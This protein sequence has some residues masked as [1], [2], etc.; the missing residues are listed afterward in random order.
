MIIDSVFKLESLTKPDIDNYYKLCSEIAK[1]HRNFYQVLTSKC[2]DTVIFNVNGPLI[3]NLQ[4][5]ALETFGYFLGICANNL[6]VP[7]LLESFLDR[8][9]DKI[10]ENYKLK[11]CP[12]Y[13]SLYL[14]AAEHFPQVLEGQQLITLDH[15]YFCMKKSCKEYRQICSKIF[16]LI[17]KKLQIKI[18]CEKVTPS[19][20]TYMH[21]ALEGNETLEIYLS[22]YPGLNN[23][24]YGKYFFENA[25]SRPYLRAKR[26]AEE[27]EYLCD[28]QDELNMN[29]LSMIIGNVAVPKE[30]QLA[31]EVIKCARSSFENFE[32]I[33]S[34]RRAIGIT[35]FICELYKINRKII[36]RQEFIEYSKQMKI[37][38]L[39]KKSKSNTICLLN[40]FTTFRVDRYLNEKV[41]PKMRSTVEELLRKF[42]LNESQLSDNLLA[43]IERENESAEIKTTK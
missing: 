30:Y 28:F 31:S 24:D 20:R 14:H 7:F 37:I 21:A 35:K 19:F 39:K 17:N 1:R 22:L 41:L 42:E 32:E 29:N 26:F 40:F 23:K 8:L 6:K 33:K 3:E 16:E 12:K 9:K 18:P 5:K 25:I 13:A 4:W 34:A 27:I 36:S 15:L 43:E 2:C 11:G 38:A 10:S